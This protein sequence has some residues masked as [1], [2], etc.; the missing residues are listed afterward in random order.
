[1]P[2]K[3][4]NFYKL[5][6]G[7]SFL[8]KEGVINNFTY[9]IIPLSKGLILDIKYSLCTNEI[10]GIF[11]LEN[12]AELEQNAFIFWRQ[13]KYII[14]RL[15][16]Q[17][18]VNLLNKALLLRIKKSVILEFIYQWNLMKYL[19]IRLNNLLTLPNIYVK[20][21][22]LENV[23]NYI[24][25]YLSYSYHVTY[26]YRFKY[27]F[28][29][30]QI[31]NSNSFLEEISNMKIMTESYK[32][33]LEYFFKN[34]LYINQKFLIQLQKKHFISIYRFS[35]KNIKRYT[36]KYILHISKL[37]RTKV[38]CVLLNLKYPQLQNSSNTQDSN[39]YLNLLFYS[40][41]KKIKCIK[42]IISFYPFI[43]FN[44][45]STVNL[46]SIIPYIDQNLIF[47]KSRIN[48]F[49][50]VKNLIPVQL[51][52]NNYQYTKTQKM[53]NSKLISKAHYLFSIYYKIYPLKYLAIYFVINYAR[54]GAY[55][56]LYLS[57]T[58]DSKLIYQNYNQLG[59][60]INLY[61]P[62]KKKP[63]IFLEYFTHDIY[64]NIIYIGTS[65]S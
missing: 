22:L 23:R 32:L 1:M 50:I 3:I 57:N 52:D 48:I 46:P 26:N 30:I 10:K 65:F 16:S 15:H 19:Q 25:S 64:K 9:K 44:Y 4:L 12:I 17:N 18:S 43:I 20:L 2:S 53:Y 7:I 42:Y 41:L 35:Y 13:L 47:L 56:I 29:Y 5:E 37:I 54:S 6:S 58:Y 55:K 28:S 8:K 39:I 34:Q 62:F 24:N 33:K 36:Y 59:I 51:F 49:D 31:L 27:N 21:S 40:N 61:L 11:N 45:E 60:G 38:L 63:I 14:Q